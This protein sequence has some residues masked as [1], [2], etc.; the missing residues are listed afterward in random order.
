MGQVTNHN[1]DG[2]SQISW[3]RCTLNININIMS[4]IVF[5]LY[6]GILFLWSRLGKP[7]VLSNH[8]EKAESQKMILLFSFLF[9]VS[10]LEACAINEETYDS[11]RN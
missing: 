10:T 6:S 3:I 4:D 2:L 11:V 1:C 5:Y 7:V 9:W 8:R